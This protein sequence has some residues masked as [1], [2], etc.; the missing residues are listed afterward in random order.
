M[1]YDAMAHNPTMAR[2]FL[3][4]LARLR[5]APARFRPR[6][7][8]GLAVVA[9]LAVGAVVFVLA[10]V[11]LERAAET[12]RPEWRDPEYGLRLKQAKRWQEKRP[13]R[14]FVLVVG[15]SRTQYGV[16]PNAM[17][18]ADEPGSPFLYNFGYRGAVPMGVLLQFTR[19]LDAGLKPRAVVVQM[20]TNEIRSHRPAEAELGRWAPRLAPADID[21]LAPYTGDAAVFRRALAAARRDPWAA[22]RAALVSI[23]LPAWQPAPVRTP[24]RSWEY[25]DPVGFCPLPPELVTA[26]SLAE[27][28]AAMPAHR[29]VINECPIG[30]VSERAHRAI[31]ARCKAEGIAV[32]LC[33]QPESPAYRAMYTPAGRAV[34]DAYAARLATDFGVPV[35]AA[36]THLADDDFADGYH[37]IEDGAERYS[38]WLA[39][40]HLKP[41]LAEAL[42]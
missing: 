42:K 12:T 25:M 33:W 31:L 40:A 19:A 30:D 2:S 1:G 9:A 6:R 21:T 14:P 26:D 17:G 22:R 7:R 15:S 20:S 35:F 16:S 10:A 18:F 34:G 24:H 11:A 38:R 36:P 5:R 3:V 23:Y 27:A 4:A 8:A 29:A 28:R 37:L 41:W 39:D 13:A 32:A